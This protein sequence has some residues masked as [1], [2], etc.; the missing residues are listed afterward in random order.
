MGK[1]HRGH[2]QGVFARTARGICPVCG[3]GAIKL[4][5]QLVVKGEQVKVCK[6]CRK[7]TAA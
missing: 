2:V 5:Y 1:T 7:K 3:T 4:F 6:R